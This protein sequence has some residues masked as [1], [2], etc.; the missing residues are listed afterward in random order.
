MSMNESEPD[1]ITSSELRA[2]A[3]VS[4]RVGFDAIAWRCAGSSSRGEG[5]ISV[6][7]QEPRRLLSGVEPESEFEY[8]VY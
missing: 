6:S 3:T 2:H 7:L 1:K 5:Q 8:G 4:G